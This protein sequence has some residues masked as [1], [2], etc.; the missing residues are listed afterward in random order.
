M[1]MLA[2]CLV[3]AAACGG[4]GEDWTKR[5]L[6][7]VIATSGGI[8]FTIEVP[9]GMRQR[10]DGDGVQWDFLIDDRVFTPDI[11]V[12]A[13][14]YAKTL[15]EYVATDKTVDQW[16]RKDTLPD[17]YIA[18]NENPSYKGREDYLVYVYKKV[19]DSAL[20]CH[21][22]VTPWRKGGKTKDQLPQLEKIC[23]SMT[24]AQK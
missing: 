3:V 8:K 17:G 10:P 16:I 7:Q 2:I 21:A 22:R 19:G 23:L 4:K 18:T 15:D 20:T 14:G 9:D 13:G 12:R 24:P 5:P 6:K 11:T 1:R